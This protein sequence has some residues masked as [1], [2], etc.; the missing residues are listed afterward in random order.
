MRSEQLQPRMTGV[1]WHGAPRQ[2][3]TSI[4]R[5]IRQRAVKRLHVSGNASSTCACH[6][7]SSRARSRCDPTAGDDGFV[8]T[9]A[10]E[11]K[12]RGKKLSTD[13]LSTDWR[14]YLSVL[15]Q[16]EAPAEPPLAVAVGMLQERLERYGHIFP[17]IYAFFYALV[18]PYSRGPRLPGDG[19]LAVFV[20]AGRHIESRPI[21]VG[22]GVRAFEEVAGLFSNAFTGLNISRVSWVPYCRLPP[23][24]SARPCCVAAGRVPAPL[25]GRVALLTGFPGRVRRR[26]L[27]SNPCTSQ[28]QSGRVAR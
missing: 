12:G 24:P 3:P 8:R 10:F 28:P 26:A 9:A 11:R 6:F 15:S 13:W 17:L 18:L 25:R 7:F 5:D 27:A 4:L 19:R 23:E 14:D 20:P 21:E 2:D 16:R 1:D 22:I